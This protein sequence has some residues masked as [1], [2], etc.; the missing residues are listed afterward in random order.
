VAQAQAESR[1]DRLAVAA[2]LVTVTLWASA[3][4]GIRAVVDDFSPGSLALGRLTVGSIALGILVLVRGLGRPSRRDLA[5][6][7]ASGL[8]WFAIY[9][10]TLNEA[11]RNLDAGTAAMLVNTGPI[12]IALFAGLFLGEGFPQRLLLGLAV[13]FGGTALIAFASSTAPAEAATRRWA[14]SCA[15]PQ[16]S[17]MRP[18]SRSR[19]R[20]CGRRRRSR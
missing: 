3:F 12:F 16:P 2:A 6:I 10:V 5:L 18:E 19:S 11:E 4:V 13:A 8:L 20:R 7:V 15:S 9:N 1:L 14:S 17:R